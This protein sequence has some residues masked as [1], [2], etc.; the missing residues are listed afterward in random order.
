MSSRI[1]SDREA[2][3]TRTGWNGEAIRNRSNIE[4]IRIHEELDAAGR[5]R[6]SSG[7]PCTVTADPPF[8]CAGLQ[9]P[10]QGAIF[11]VGSGVGGS[12]GPWCAVKCPDEG[13]VV[14]YVGELDLPTATIF[15]SGWR[16]IAMIDV[17]AAA[18]IWGGR[19]SR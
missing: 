16:R 4:I 1:G 11:P 15:P 9:R 18:T 13:D 19:E 17:L 2:P 5:R 8:T 14:I 7:S 3:R 12:A 6:P 10:G